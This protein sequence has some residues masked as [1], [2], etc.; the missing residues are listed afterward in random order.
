MRFIKRLFVNLLLLAI[1]LTV[2][3]TISPEIM[4]GIYQLY[5]GIL[6]PGLV[7]LWLVVTALPLFDALVSDLRD[8]QTSFH[9]L[10]N[11]GASTF[12]QNVAQVF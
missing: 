4:G 9:R 11:T 5:I 8:L 12:C 10:C 7:L 1:L 2:P 3:D 6:G